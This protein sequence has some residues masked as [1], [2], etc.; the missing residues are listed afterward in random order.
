M[1]PRPLPLPGPTQSIADVS[2]ADAVS[3]SRPRP[4]GSPPVSQPTS[5]LEDVEALLD[6]AALSGS[7]SSKRSPEAADEL[8][9]LLERERANRAAAEARV[10]ALEKEVE[11]RDAQMITERRHAKDSAESLRTAEDEVDKLSLANEALEARVDELV[12]PHPV[13]PDSKLCHRKGLTRISSHRAIRF[14]CAGRLPKLRALCPARPADAVTRAHHLAGFEPLQSEES[15]SMSSR[16]A[17][18]DSQT[19]DPAEAR[20]AKRRRVDDEEHDKDGAEKEDSDD[21]DSSDAASATDSRR[22]R[23][24]L[25]ARYTRG[26]PEPLSERCV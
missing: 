17:P 14:R 25:D 20:P 26:L 8:R 9:A 10:Q 23:T 13:G 6:A 3:S 15:R 1:T 18:T 4:T 12:S 22:P 24:S 2:H 19:P 5:E 21:G 11:Q 16:S 7:E